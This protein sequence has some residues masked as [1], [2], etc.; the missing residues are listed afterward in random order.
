MIKKLLTVAALAVTT[1]SAVAEN[2]SF[3]YLDVG[4]ANWDFDNAGN[5]DG[6]EIKGSGEIN[7][8]FYI[9]GDYTRISESGDDIDLATLG[10][11]YKYNYT[12]SSTFFAEL[13]Y[14]SLNPNFGGSE[15]GY[16]VTVGVRSMITNEFEL[17]GAVEYLDINGD[18]TS[19]VL[20]GAYNFTSN[21][22]A[23][24]NY[25]FESDIN[26]YAVG[27]RYNF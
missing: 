26:R 23:Y 6:F 18:S 16:E 22:G 25:K 20:G 19:L 15:S 11:G 4:Y 3:N 21:F 13:D 24:A 9:A 2:P 17:N 1:F 5:V 27:L 12:D 8:N 7:E 14:A 10:L